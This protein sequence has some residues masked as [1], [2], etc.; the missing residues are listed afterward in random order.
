MMKE[1]SFGHLSSEIELFYLTRAF[2]TLSKLDTNT[3]GVVPCI[4]SSVMK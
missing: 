3:N 4:V 2:Y 1:S